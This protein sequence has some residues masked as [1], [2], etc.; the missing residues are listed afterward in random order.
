MK[1]HRH[2][3]VYLRWSFFRKKFSKNIKLTKLT[4]KVT[5]KYKH[6]IKLEEKPSWKTLNNCQKNAHKNKTE[7]SNERKHKK[8][9]GHS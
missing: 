1:R 2:S 8:E 9:N 7:N 3:G 4:N 6:D 5:I